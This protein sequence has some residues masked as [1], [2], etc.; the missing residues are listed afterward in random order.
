MS[1]SNNNCEVEP[2]SRTFS[3]HIP[4]KPEVQFAIGTVGS[5]HD[6]E[7]QSHNN[8]RKYARRGSK[9]PFMLM[10]NVKQLSPVSDRDISMSD[11]TPSRKRRMSVVS[12]LILQFEDSIC[13]ETKCAKRDR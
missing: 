13:I 1:T 3:E 4:K 11:S 12:S 9:T 6:V 7:L 5:I 10:L 2:T 8:R